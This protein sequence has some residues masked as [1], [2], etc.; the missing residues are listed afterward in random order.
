MGLIIPKLPIAD[1][2]TSTDLSQLLRILCLFAKSK[3]KTQMLYDVLERA[4]AFI[5]SLN[6]KPVDGNSRI[7][8]K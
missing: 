7:D 5:T 6:E 8:Y 1:Y 4:M 2:G 3:Q